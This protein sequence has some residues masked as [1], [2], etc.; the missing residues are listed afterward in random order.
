MAETTHISWTDATWNPWLGC[1]KTGSAACVPC[2]AEHLVQNRFGRAV[3]GGPH[4]GA[5][6]RVKTSLT[7]W[8]TPNKL[9]RQA[10]AAGTPLFCFCASLSDIFDPVAPAEWRAEAFA[11]MRSTPH[12]I[13]LLLTKRPH[14]IVQLATAAGGLPANA[15]IL[16]TVVTQ[17]EAERD[18]PHLLNAAA[19]LKPLFTGLSLEPLVEPIDLTK[20]R[21]NPPPGCTK[22][23][24]WALNALE[25]R[26]AP[27]IY[28][29]SGEWE[30]D[31]GGVRGPK[32]NWVI[33]GGPTDQG[34]HKAW[35]MSIQWVREVRDQ[36]AITATPFHFKQ[37][38]EWAPA[39]LRPSE[40][41]GRFA[42]GDYSHDRKVMH[43]TDHYP[44][45][46]TMF[47]ARSVMER[48]GKKAAGRLLD[49]VLHNDRPV[50]AA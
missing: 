35:P 40:T 12:V 28:T 13:Y 38:G 3:W 31:G 1:Q 30:L 33:C 43:Q 11:K 18:V 9:E 21:V 26:T 39:R 25:G 48:V 17:A 44:R 24:N 41:P 14:L 8:A 7:T 6:T 20:L 37:W 50:V 16:C 29:G 46:F 42:F 45:Q 4:E 36:C 5:G 23:D 2:Y 32:I 15:A 10:I 49:G 22:D 27:I 34:A 19:K 47:G